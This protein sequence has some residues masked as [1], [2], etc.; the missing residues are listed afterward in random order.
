[1]TPPR[2]RAR[3]AAAAAEPRRPAISARAFPCQFLHHRSPCAAGRARRRRASAAGAGMSRDRPGTWGRTDLGDRRR[4]SR[5]SRR[6]HARRLRV[7]PD[8]M[9]GA[10]VLFLPGIGDAT[11]R[12]T[13]SRALRG[14]V[15]RSPAPL[16]VSTQRRAPLLSRRS[17]SN[18]SSSTSEAAR[19]ATCSRSG[20]RTGCD[21]LQGVGVRHRARWAERRRRS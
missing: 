14:T 12:S 8:A 6:S 5:S 13:R 3:S 20:R 10:R 15:L 1:M 19:C 16:A 2:Y 18:G 9:A 17:C 4:R 7:R 21:M 11:A